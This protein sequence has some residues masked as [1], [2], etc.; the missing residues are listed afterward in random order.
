MIGDV[1]IGVVGCGEWGELV[2]FVCFD[3]C[4]Y[5]G[6]IYLKIWF[7]DVLVGCG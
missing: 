4:Y 6:W 1:V 2:W 5:F 7:V 3:Y